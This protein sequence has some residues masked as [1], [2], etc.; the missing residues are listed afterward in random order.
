MNPV[1]GL[2][3]GRHLLTVGVC[4]EQAVLLPVDGYH[5]AYGP[6]L[7]RVGFDELENGFGPFLEEGVEERNG[8]S[9]FRYGR[10]ASKRGGD[11]RIED[12]ND[13]DE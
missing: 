3:K 6:D 1:S 5:A 10:S 7:N 2:Q 11:A 9:S 12:G 13:E 8:R 4:G